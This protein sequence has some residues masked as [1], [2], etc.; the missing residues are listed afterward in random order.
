MLMLNG[1]L[2]LQT[3]LEIATNARINLSGPHQYFIEV[4]YANH[5]VVS[6]SPVK[7]LFANDCGMQIMMDYIK[8]PLIEPDTSCLDDLKPVDFHG[9][10]L[11]ALYVMGTLNIWDNIG[12]SKKSMKLEN[13]SSLLTGEGREPIIQIPRWP[14]IKQ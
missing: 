5:G 13:K 10:P 12:R 11:I 7:T 2:D 14:F 4:P 9:N 1:T 3:P 8:D 6:S